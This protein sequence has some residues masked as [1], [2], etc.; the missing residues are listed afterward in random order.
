MGVKNYTINENSV[1]DVNGDVDLSFKNMEE[2]PIQFGIVKG[3]FN[4][5][6]NKLKSLK[7]SPKKCY[8]L[9]C[10]N[11]SITNLDFCPKC[12]RLYCK[13]NNLKS[14]KGLSD[15]III[16]SDLKEDIKKQKNILTQ[17]PNIIEFSDIQISDIIKKFNSLP[18]KYNNNVNNTFFVDIVK[19]IIKNRRC[20]KKQYEHLSYLL[21]NGMSMNETGFLSTKN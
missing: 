11:N 15:D 17:N 2:I 18:N 14:L 4:C 10:S 20:S 8:I 19:S 1:V 5:S 3:F 21:K 6:Y 12:E 7:G 13:N 16:S 9:Y